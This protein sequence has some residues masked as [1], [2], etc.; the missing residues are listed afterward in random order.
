MKNHT[1]LMKN[2]LLHTRRRGS[3]W[4]TLPAFTLAALFATSTGF[5]DYNY[6]SAQSGNWHDSGTW[7]ISESVFKIKSNGI[8]A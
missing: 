8:N 6:F 2:H 7:N 4:R 1:G 3:L 5:A